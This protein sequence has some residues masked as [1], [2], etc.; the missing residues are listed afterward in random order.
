MNKPQKT[1]LQ[2]T[3]RSN[4]LYGLTQ[5]ATPQQKHSIQRLLID[6]Q[7]KHQ[8]LF[9]TDE[10]ARDLLEAFINITKPSTHTD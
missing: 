1:N 7:E 10:S 2:T 6:L 4:I 9:E 5:N 8:E 3:I